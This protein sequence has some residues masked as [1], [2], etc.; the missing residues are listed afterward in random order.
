MTGSHAPASFG[1]MRSVRYGESAHDRHTLT[2]SLT[3]TP[4]VAARFSSMRYAP[5]A[6]IGSCIAWFRAMTGAVHL[7]DREC[8][9]ILLCRSARF[10]AGGLGPVNAREARREKHVNRKKLT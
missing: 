5:F 7:I 2:I 1:H 10:A 9:R 3:G 8:L 4:R 6:R